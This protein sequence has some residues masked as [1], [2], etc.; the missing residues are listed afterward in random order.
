VRSNL[1][2]ERVEGEGWGGRDA[3]RVRDAGRTRISQRLPETANEGRLE[4]RRL[5]YRNAYR[6]P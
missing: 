3:I 2:V 4:K 5:V 1:W 6:L